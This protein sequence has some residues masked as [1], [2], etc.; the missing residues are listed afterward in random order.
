[1]STRGT[2]RRGTGGRGRG[3]GSARAG[4]SVS[5]LMPNVEAR[6]VLASPVTETGSFD[7]AAGDDVL[8]QAMLHILKRV[9]R[10]SNGAVGPPQREQDFAALV[11]K[12][13]IAEDVKRS[14]RQN[15][16]KDRGRFKRDL[17]PS[18]SSKRPK[19][20]ARFD[21]P[22]G[23]GVSV[24]RPQSRTDCGRYHLGECWKKIGA[25]FRCGSK[26][27]QVKDCPQMP[28][29]MQAVRGG[30]GV[31]Q[32]RGTFG[33][34]IGNSEARQLTLVCAA[35]HREDG[36]AL[37]V[38]TGS[39]HSYI[40]CTVSGTLGIMCESTV[41]KMTVLSPL[42]QSVRVDKLFRDVPLEVQEIIFLADLM[43]LPFGEFDLI[44]GM[45]W[46][47]KH[48]A[49][50]DCAAKRM[51]LKAIED[52]EVVVIGEQRD[53]L[54]NVISALSVEKLVRKGCETFL[55]YIGA[56]V[57]K[58]LSV[59]DV[60]IVKDFFDVFLDKL[61]RLPPSREV[62]FGIELL[63][64]TASVSF[65]SKSEGVLC[66][67]QLSKSLF[68]HSI[69]LSVKKIAVNFRQ[70]FRWA[71]PLLSVEILGIRGSYTLSQ[72]GV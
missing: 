16:E 56:S 60:R 43:E 48:C 67:L 50:L 7:R 20:K 32:I 22:V 57:S 15:C 23:A 58:G 25:C 34:G 3:R 13:E 59:R 42:G 71:K 27:H 49:S 26:E 17:E 29:Q 18:S 70:W 44:L 65:S 19:K 66:V 33:R 41:N 21:G 37:D 61:P 45:D 35:R 14:E 36:D 55:A 62:E 6:E 24:A 52:D 2:H 28:T 69:K 11:E 68:H 46:L 63:P 47:V 54:S 72:T 30:N 38:I 12:V 10:T 8:S 31:G 53:F 4:S 51:V 1:M 5:G 39:T 9:V 64:G 40:A